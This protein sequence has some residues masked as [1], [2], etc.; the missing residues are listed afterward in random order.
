VTDTTTFTITLVVYDGMDFS[1]RDTVLIT[2]NQV[3]KKPVADAGPDQ[4]AV[5]EGDTVT[6]DG[7]DSF[8]PDSDPITFE[9]RAPLGISLNDSTNT[10][11]TF[12][13]PEVTGD[14]TYTFTLVVNDG[15]AYSTRDTVLITVKQVNKIPVAD[16]GPDQLDVDEGDPVAL[17]GSDSF[18]PDSDPLTF[19]WRAPIGISLDDSTSTYP[20]F[21]APEVTDTTTF[22]FTLVVY[23]GTDY[24]A[25]DTVLIT[26]NQVNKPPVADAGDDQIVNEGDTVYLDGSDSYF[27]P[28]SDPFDGF[29]WTSPAG[30]TLSSDTVSNPTFKA[31]E[32]SDDTTYTFILVVND[33][34]VDSEP[35]TVLITV[36]NEVAVPETLS[37]VNETIGFEETWCYDALQ[38]I[39]VAGG[40]TTVNFENGSIVD[41]IAGQKISFLPG[42]HAYS[43]S[44]MHAYISTSFCEPPGDVAQPD[45]PIKSA[46]IS[47]NVPEKNRI[48]EA[49][50]VKVYPNPND[51]RF[52]VELRNFDS[53]VQLTIVNTLGIVVFTKTST[54]I[55]NTALD[56]RYLNRG[57]YF[58]RVKS[59]N[60]LQTQKIIIR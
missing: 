20:A 14:T 54:F 11:P 51:G 30:I 38:V 42:F 47:R 7:S 34:P 8:D 29:L 59:D 18:D 6:L 55:E 40:G 17:D 58:V 41:L 37:V 15:L 43:G 31:P 50:Y 53:P 5:N 46:D 52:I 13:A 16:A 9:W 28:G 4:A 23:D 26:V 25:R 48:S 32:V 57:L 3:N 10:Q 56:I 49:K 1:A 22:T 35:D 12:T 2:V 19:E 44:L 36:Q 39:T 21:T 24:S 60:F 27:D 33:G 45:P